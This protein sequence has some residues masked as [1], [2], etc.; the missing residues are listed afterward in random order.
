MGKKRI[1]TFYTNTFLSTAFLLLSC[2]DDKPTFTDAFLVE[3]RVDTDSKFYKEIRSSYKKDNKKTYDGMKIRA[4]YF[5]ICASGGDTDSVCGPR[6]N[7]TDLHIYSP[8]NVY[9]SSNNTK[10]G[11]K[12]I[13]ATLDPITLAGMF[14]NDIVNPV[15][16]ILSLFFT[17]VAF[18]SSLWTGVETLP[19]QSMIQI[20]AYSS[21]MAAWFFWSIGAI[22]FQVAGIATTKMVNQSSLSILEASIGQRAA[23]M[24][25]TAFGF[26]FLSILISLVLRRK[27]IKAQQ[28]TAG[29]LEP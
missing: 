12:E 6:S 2:F 17:I 7:L 22:W 5:G 28:L 4:G 13:I 16:V 11:R 23:A 20:V 21:I 26:L 1:W 27:Q 24:T 14:S 19:K 10:E 18:I 25:W 3:Y 8:V 29:K 15:F 9:G